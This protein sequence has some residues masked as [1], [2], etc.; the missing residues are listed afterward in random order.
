MEKLNPVDIVRA[1]KEAVPSAVRHT[2][3]DAWNIVLGNRVAQWQLENIVKTQAKSKKLF[4]ELGLKPNL[5]KIPPRYGYAWFEEAAKHDEPDLQDLFATLL[6]KAAS[7]DEDALDTRLLEI[8]TKFT[9]AEAKLFHYLADAV[10]GI[11]NL[12]SGSLNHGEFAGFPLQSLKS[13][14]VDKFGDAYLKALEHLISVG[15][16]QIIYMVTNKSVETVHD[17]M[18]RSKGGLMAFAKP[19]ITQAEMI[20]MLNFSALGKSLIEAVKLPR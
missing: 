3:T 5:D 2:L 9:P 4:D 18:E 16:I 15:V 10:E 8:V 12:K 6:A 13:E 11:E 19:H 14:I 17:M 20:T 7:G 1:G